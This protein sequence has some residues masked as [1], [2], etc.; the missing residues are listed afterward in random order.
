MSKIWIIRSKLRN[1]E[2]WSFPIIDKNIYLVILKFKNYLILTM[3]VQTAPI[4]I[5]KNRIFRVILKYLLNWNTRILLQNICSFSGQDFSNFFQLNTEL[6]ECNAVT[7]I[8]QHTFELRGGTGKGYNYGIIFLVY[9]DWY[10]ITDVYCNF[11]LK[12]NS[13]IQNAK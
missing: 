1:F 10:G 2:H 3:R 5:S 9:I 7:K 4:D 8:A 6:P 11:S 13:N 12:K